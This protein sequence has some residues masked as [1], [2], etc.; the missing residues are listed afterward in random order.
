M[1]DYVKSALLIYRNVDDDLNNLVEE[2]SISVGTIPQSG[3]AS[4]PLIVNTIKNGKMEF[5]V[6]EY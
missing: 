1:T 5:I 6:K 3:K 2:I 4:W